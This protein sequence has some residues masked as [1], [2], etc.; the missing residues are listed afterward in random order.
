VDGGFF[1]AAPRT[2]VNCTAP[3]NPIGG[4]CV[5]PNCDPAQVDFVVQ[6]FS[7]YD[8]PIPGVCFKDVV[9]KP[10]NRQLVSQLTFR[11]VAPGSFR[12]AAIEGYNLV[13]DCIIDPEPK[14]DA[15][16]IDGQ[17]I[18][19]VEA[20]LVPAMTN[21]GLG[22]FA[23]LLAGTFIVMARRQRRG[24][25]LVFL[26]A[27]ALAGGLIV[28]KTVLA[29]DCP[30]YCSNGN[31]DVNK[32]GRIIVSDAQIVLS[33]A[34]AGCGNTAYDVTGNG[35]VDMEDYAAVMNCIQKRCGV[36]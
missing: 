32:D 1:Q 8:L 6:V 25:I 17:T 18:Q 29:A 2:C 4:N 19:I 27:L 22:V 26:L 11:A 33:C 16:L 35:A 31:A 34:N 10:I 15:L 28:G 13:T 14:E 24:R 23:L 21:V 30:D 36:K 5:P 12:L 9:A 20:S 7:P 3:L